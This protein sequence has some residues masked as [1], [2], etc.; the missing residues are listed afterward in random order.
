[1]F[2]AFPETDQRDVGSLAGAHRAE[3][4]DLDLACDHLV[5]QRHHDRRDQSQAILALVGDKHA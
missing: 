3:V 2:G 4:C 1:V 5:P